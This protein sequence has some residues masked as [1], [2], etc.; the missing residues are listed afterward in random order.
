MWVG[1]SCPLLNPTI[2]F[3][4]HVPSISI[5]ELFNSVITFHGVENDAYIEIALGH[6]PEFF[7]LMCLLTFHLQNIHICAKVN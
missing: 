2:Y 1:F 3:L 5:S 6:V 7:F 4:T